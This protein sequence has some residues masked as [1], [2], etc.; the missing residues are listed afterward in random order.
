MP[1]L[2]TEIIERIFVSLM[3]SFDNV[4]EAHRERSAKFAQLSIISR[5]FHA[6][7]NRNGYYSVNTGEMLMELWLRLQDPTA[8]SGMRSLRLRGDNATDLHIMCRII[9]ICASAANLKRLTLRFGESENLGELEQFHYRRG[10]V[11]DALQGLKNVEHFSGEWGRFSNE[12]ALCRC[13]L[14]LACLAH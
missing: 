10:L 14:P 4:F 12:T 13:V 1:E 11:M 8:V 7:T 3:E 5:L 9:S 2:P 6:L